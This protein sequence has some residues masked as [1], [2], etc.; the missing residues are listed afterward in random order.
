MP[1]MLCAGPGLRPH[2]H[3]NLL[4]MSD[5]LAPETAAARLA[6][7]AFGVPADAVIDF[8]KHRENHVYR[9]RTPDWDRSLRMHRVGYRSDEDLRSETASMATFG[10]GGIAVPTPIATPG[11]DHVVAVIDAEGTRRQATMQEWVADG[12]VF[13]DSA[14]VFAGTARPSDSELRM[15]GGLIA[16]MHNVAAGGAPT[17]YSRAAWNADGLA[18]PAALWGSAARLDSLSVTDRLTLERADARLRVDLAGLPTTPDRFGVIHADF[19][20]ENVLV[21]DHGL[22]ALD[23]DDSG[24]GWFL[25]DLATPAFWCARHLDGPAMI[26]ALAAGYRQVRPLPDQRGW[27]ALLL[28]RALSYLGWAADR[29]GDPAS[30]FHEHVVAPWVIAAAGRYLKSGETGWPPLALPPIEGVTG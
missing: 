30:D 3:H 2:R 26:A 13:G 16:R 22:V 19:T 1:R 29:P 12:R 14:A 6:L 15:L 21:T 11:G 10:A 24:E 8:V 28:A 25:F 23:F 20:F 9:V 7:D 4:L 18:G 17:D 27:H 5:D